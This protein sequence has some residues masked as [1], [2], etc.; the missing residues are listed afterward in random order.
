MV[1]ISIEGNP[2]KLKGNGKTATLALLAKAY[3][4]QRKQVYSNFSLSFDHKKI[5]FGN[6]KNFE[7]TNGVICI[8]EIQSVL[9]AHGGLSKAKR[10]ANHFLL[11]GRHVDTDIIFSTQRFKNVHTVLRIQVDYRIVVS[12][13][14]RDGTECFIDNCKEDHVFKMVL[15]SSGSGKSKIAYF[16]DTQAYGLYDTKELIGVDEAFL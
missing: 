4:V 10:G 8:D 5:D 9:P 1:V 14:H 15:L 6:L 2:N 16:K 7:Y 12:K 13:L 3:F 11:Q